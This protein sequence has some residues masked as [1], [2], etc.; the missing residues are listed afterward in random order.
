[1]LQSIATTAVMGEY[2]ESTDKA[3]VLFRSAL[4]GSRW[5]GSQNLLVG[6]GYSKQ[7]T[8]GRKIF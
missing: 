1:M 6:A 5:C 3:A 8:Q 4:A 7:F 2:G